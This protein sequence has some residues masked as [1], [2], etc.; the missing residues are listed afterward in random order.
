MT[1]YLP[2][3][4]DSQSRTTAQGRGFRFET[5]GYD[6]GVFAVRSHRQPL[7]GSR[8][9]LLQEV[10]AVDVLWWL[11]LIAVATAAVAVVLLLVRRARRAGTVLAS[12][13]PGPSAAERSDR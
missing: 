9:L 3:R 13:S 6:P 7:G 5:Y 2:R 11:A 4:G 1:V 10:V 12:R 8:G